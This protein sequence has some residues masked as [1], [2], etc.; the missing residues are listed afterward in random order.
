M[1]GI[2]STTSGALRPSTGCFSS[3]QPSPRPPPELRPLSRLR[4]VDEISCDFNAAEII[5]I[6]MTAAGKADKPFWLVRQRE[7]PLAKRNR[8]RRI[9]RAMQHQQRNLDPR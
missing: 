1:K 7:Q 8:Y 4:K 3:A 6:V 5:Q 2:K 9:E